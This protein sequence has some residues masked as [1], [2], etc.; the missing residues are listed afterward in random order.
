M[1]APVAAPAASSPGRAAAASRTPATGWSGWLPGLSVVALATVVCAAVLTIPSDPA[2]DVLHY[3]YWT[4]QIATYGVSGSYSGTYPETAAIYPPVT[5]YGYRVAGWLY[6]HLYDLTFDMDVALE[7]QPL[8]VL[9]KLVAVVPHL[10]CALAIFALLKRRFGSGPATL[11]TAAY[12]LNPAAIFD[13]AYWGQPDAVH[14]MFLLIA[15]YWFEED[16]PLVGYAFI[17]LAAAT[18]PQAWALLPFLGYVSLRRFGLSTS[19]VGA[20]VAGLTA[21]A[22]CIPFIVYG[23]FSELFKLPGLIAETMQVVSANA[24]NVWWIVTRGK[25]DFVWDGE[26]LIGPLTYRQAAAGL[27]L[28]VM[29]FGLWRTNPRGR[30]GELSATAAYLAFAWFMVTTR[31]HENHAF[32]VL[33]LLV[34]ATPRSRFVWA[35]FGVLSL[36]L[37]LNMAYHDFGLEAWRLSVLPPETWLRLQLANAALNLLLLIVW[38]ARLLVPERRARAM[39][40]AIDPI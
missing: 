27:T 28:M 38:S 11:A 35:L 15:I 6:R 34:M 33:P 30:D 12:A 22:T 17:G 9:D 4:R 32:F 7:S 14:A 21:L 37:F 18:K 13:A 39:M 3:K 8:A 5:M 26:P 2:S 16:R 31:A 1:S 24:H 10:L 19:V 23:T 40:A 25:P 29:A 20:V 36:T